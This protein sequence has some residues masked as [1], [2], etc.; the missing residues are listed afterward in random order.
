[1]WREHTLGRVQMHRSG[2]T[3]TLHICSKYV[4]IVCSQVNQV[5]HLI[6]VTNLAQDIRLSFYIKTLRIIN[7]NQKHLF[8]TSGHNTHIPHV[9]FIF[10]SRKTSLIVISHSYFI[11][12]STTSVRVKPGGPQ[13]TTHPAF[14]PWCWCWVPPSYINTFLPLWDHLTPLGWVQFQGRYSW[15]FLLLLGYCF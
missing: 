6:S 10:I 14:L 15:L 1:M 12:G 13:V 5:S 2:H 3:L 4:V 11:D 7:Q 8:T 9:K